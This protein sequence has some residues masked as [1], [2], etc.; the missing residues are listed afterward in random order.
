MLKGT[1]PL[2]STEPDKIEFTARLGGGTDKADLDYDV[3]VCLVDASGNEINSTKTTVATGLTNDPV[4]Y[5]VS[6]PYSASAYGVKLMHM[7]E[8]GWN[9]RYYSFKLSYSYTESYATLLGTETGGGVESVAMKFNAKISTTNWSALGTVSDYGIMMF[10]RKSSDSEY[11]DT[12][13]PVKDAYRDGRTL[14]VSRKG[15][16]DGVSQ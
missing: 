10:K 11:S 3:E 8:N 14:T 4:N 15:S 7:K 6:V 16:G 2:F 13:T 5:T 9:A 12:S 1:S